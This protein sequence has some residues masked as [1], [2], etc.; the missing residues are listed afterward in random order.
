MHQLIVVRKTVYTPEQKPTLSLVLKVL[1]NKGAPK[2]LPQLF[3]KV[4]LQR[5]KSWSQRQGHHSCH[6]ST[7]PQCEETSATTDSLHQSA[8]FR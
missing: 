4:P 6:K 5:Q 1:D 3:A 2:D 8:G 7:S